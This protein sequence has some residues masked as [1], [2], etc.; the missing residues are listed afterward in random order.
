MKVNVNGREY[1][2]NLVA[3]YMDEEIKS[4][5]EMQ[6]WENEQEWV[7]AY[8]EAHFTKYGEDFVIN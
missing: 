3:A 6:W 2:A 1:D 7:D 4:D 8:C 5:L